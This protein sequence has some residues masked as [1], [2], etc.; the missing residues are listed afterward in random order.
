MGRHQF[1]RRNEASLQSAVHYFREAIALDEDFALAYTGL[2]D[3]Y[4]LLANHGAGYGNIP[5]QES[6]SL[7]T[8]LVAKALE[9][10]PEL[11]EAYASQGHLLRLQGDQTGAEEALRR[12]ME[13]NPDYP[14]SHVW[15]GLTLSNQGRLKEARAEY[16]RAHELDPLSPIVN[17]NLGFDN[18]RFGH[19]ED[20]RRQFM[21]VID[22]DPA[23]PIAYSG[24]AQLERTLGNLRAAMEWRQKA[25]NASPNRSYYYCL[26]GGLRLEMGD[27]DG[28]EK[29]IEHAAGLTPDHPAVIEHK[30]ALHIARSDYTALLGYTLDLLAA[31]PENELRMGNVALTYCLTDDFELAVE[32]YQ[33]VRT[34][35]IRWFNDA[36][37]CELELSA[38]AV[39]RERARKAGSGR[40]VR[41]T[42]GRVSVIATVGA[43]GGDRQSGAAVCRRRHARPKGQGR[44][45]DLGAH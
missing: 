41:S 22:L 27:I 1:H 26:L 9:L 29:A 3:A 16:Q 24:M 7:A 15:L 4:M 12:A 2:S 5:L 11:G 44:G 25:V 34:V 6:I 40:R 36:L 31:E 14:M 33:R 21:W 37:V 35:L 28:A 19:F 8:P 42:V 43:G 45:R 38:R 39:L 32:H 10:N 17:T 20:A 13:L 23:F 18:L 30:M